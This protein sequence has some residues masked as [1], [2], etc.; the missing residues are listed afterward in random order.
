MSNTV[1]DQ[2][3]QPVAAA[4]PLLSAATKLGKVGLVV[5]NLQRSLE[6]YADI[7]GLQ[8]LAQSERSAQLGITAENRILLELEQREGVRKLIGKRLG[9]YHF[10]LLLPSRADLSSFAE[11]LQT[12]GVRAGMSDHLVSEAFYLEDPDGLQIEVYADRDPKE[13][14]WDGDE[15]AVATQPLDLR[16]LLSHRH[17]PWA[18]APLGSTIGHIHLYIGDIPRADQLYHHGLGM[19]VR[20]RSF[21]GALFLAAGKYHHHVGLNTWAGSVPVASETDA[22]LSIWELQVP[23]TDLITLSDRMLSNGWQPLESTTFVDP[24]GIALRLVAVQ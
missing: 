2:S 5:S 10:A 22:R 18:G 3:L 14:L 20:S 21:P 11:H 15:I 19:N 7:I 24:W 6:F 23:L 8:V 1:E 9:L 17:Q 16:K 13:W 12:A 4:L